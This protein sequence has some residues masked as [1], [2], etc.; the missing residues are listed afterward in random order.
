MTLAP[1]LR[2]AILVCGPLMLALFFGSGLITQFELAHCPAGAFLTGSELNAVL[3]FA[4]MIGT[5]ALV[6]SI[7]AAI[8]LATPGI[9]AQFEGKEGLGHPDWRWMLVISV[10]VSLMSFAVVTAAALSSFCLAPSSITV[11]DWPWEKPHV[12]AWRD[13]S[14][15]TTRCW[16]G[17]GWSPSFVLKMNDGRA[18]E[19]QRTDMAWVGAYPRIAK[20]LQGVAFTFDS[21]GVAANCGG[22]YADLLR[23]RP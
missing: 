5:M 21:T 11:R 4:V 18:L 10:A 16:Y 17:H 8:G 13:V 23:R 9:R 22:D 15:V 2:N 3:W 19:L 14:A 1:R 7:I 12:Y 20:A 6:L